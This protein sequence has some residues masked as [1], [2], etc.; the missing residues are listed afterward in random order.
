MVRLDAESR[1]WAG[2]PPARA[3]GRAP[4]S[5]TFHCVVHVTPSFHG[6]AARHDLMPGYLPSL[7]SQMMVLEMLSRAPPLILVVDMVI[8]SEK[9]LH[10]VTPV[11]IPW[12]DWGPQHTCYFPHH[13]SHRIS[14]LGSKMACALPRDRSPAPGERMEGLSTPDCD[15]F[16]V[17]IWD[18][19]KRAIA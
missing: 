11:K 18:F 9:A 8:F 14:V 16:Y 1:M 3:S 12:M 6:S 2:V 10:S 19:N 7:E 4:L 17:H 13:P 15:K 5:F